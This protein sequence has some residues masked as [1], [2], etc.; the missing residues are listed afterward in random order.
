MLT[1]FNEI[2]YNIEGES[3]ESKYKRDVYKITFLYHTFFYVLP[4]PVI[5]KII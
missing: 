5:L 1:G 4:Q 2:I 3:I